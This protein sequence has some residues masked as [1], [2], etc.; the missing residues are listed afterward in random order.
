MGLTPVDARIKFP[1]EVLR[2]FTSVTS[3]RQLGALKA[4]G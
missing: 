4:D 3:G 2:A 1:V